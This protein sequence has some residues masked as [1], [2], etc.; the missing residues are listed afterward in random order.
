MWTLILLPLVAA[1]AFGVLAW[2]HATRFDRQTDRE[3]WRHSWEPNGTLGLALGAL[4]A[5]VAAA[6]VL[7]LTF[8][9]RIVP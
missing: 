3:S 2:H 5:A 1:L 8:L 7:Q 4:V 9:P 6:T